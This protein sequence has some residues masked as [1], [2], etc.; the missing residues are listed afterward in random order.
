MEI[1]NDNLKGLNIKELALDKNKFGALTFDTSYPLLEKLRSLFVEF[2]ELDYKANLTK[3]EVNSIDSYRNQFLSY[4]K[5]LADF[6]PAQGPDFSRNIRDGF[7]N[8]VKSFD[9]SMFKNVRNS[10]VYLRQEA[11]L[12]STD[13]KQ[14]HEQKKASIQAEKEYK[15]LSE[16]LKKEL[17]DLEKRKQQIETARGEVAATTLA[18]RF[19]KQAEEYE[20][21][22]KKWLSRRNIWLSFLI[23]IISANV[24]LYFAIF[25]LNRAGVIKLTVDNIFTIQYA[26]AKIV[27]LSVISYG[28]TFASKHYGIDSNLAAINTHRRNVAQT[29]DDFLA[30]NP[31]GETRSQMISQGV[32]AMFKHLPAGYL[33]REEHRDISLLYE[34]INKVLPSKNI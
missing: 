34:V 17:D 19:E 16:K 7:E 29:L 25:F 5:R 15:N 23:S 10:F 28:V 27:F 13:E 26:I 6:D 4:L 21:D 1:S 32:E 22:A 33:K 24:V 2:D 11:A 20:K 14:L 30:T 18:V 3:D 12:K 8:E 31:D 9:S